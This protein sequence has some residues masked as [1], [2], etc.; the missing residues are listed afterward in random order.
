[1]MPADKFWEMAN[2]N[3]CFTAWLKRVDGFCMRLLGIDLF[4]IP[5][6][7]EEPYYPQDSYDDDMAPAA[8]FLWLVNG[9]KRATPEAEIDIQV[10]RMTKW[11][12]RWPASLA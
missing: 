4:S 12:G 1:M 8:Y 10:A 2:G 7:L 5:E 6:A 11:G 3:P 9:M